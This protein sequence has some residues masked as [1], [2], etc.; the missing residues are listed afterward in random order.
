MYEHLT[1]E[2]QEKVLKKWEK[3]LDAGV[4]IKGEET[5][6]A[7]ALVLEATQKEF[8]FVGPKQPSPKFDKYGPINDVESLPPIAIAKYEDIKSEKENQ[9]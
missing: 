9:D 2:Y 3:L 1:A 7:T 6:I 5:R 4:P 8:E